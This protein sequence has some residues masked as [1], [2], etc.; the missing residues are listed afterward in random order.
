MDSA[1]FQ[2]SHSW[3]R[4]AVPTIGACRHHIC[5]S[6]T[7][8]WTSTPQGASYQLPK[9]RWGLCGVGRVVQT[10]I[11]FSDWGMLCVIVCS[12]G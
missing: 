7:C 9:K 6:G 4:E 2:L 11:G 10:L 5:L 3:S 8:N 12:V 1:D